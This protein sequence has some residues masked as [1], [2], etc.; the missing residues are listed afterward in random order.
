MTIDENDDM[1]IERIVEKIRDEKDNMVAPVIEVIRNEIIHLR[2]TQDI[3]VSDLLDYGEL[4]YTIAKK[5]CM[6]DLI[7]SIKDAVNVKI[8]DLPGNRV[9]RIELDLAVL[10][11]KGEEK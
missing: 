8:T 5:R 4:V 10:R 1:D 2:A 9:K 3:L 7:D 11:R 6:N